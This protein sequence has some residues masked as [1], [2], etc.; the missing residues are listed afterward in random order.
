M[1]IFKMGYIKQFLSLTLLIFSLI[2][3]TEELELKCGCEDNG[4]RQYSVSVR[5]ND[6][7]IASELLRELD[8]LGRDIY[9]V[10][11]EKSSDTVY[12]CAENQSNYRELEEDLFR[13][14]KFR[15]EEFE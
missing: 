12:F 13:E 11:L 5:V 3:C 9:G 1:E 6:I 4:R 10:C 2:G 15:D 14:L 7:N 8:V